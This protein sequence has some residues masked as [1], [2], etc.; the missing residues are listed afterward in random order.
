MRNLHEAFEQAKA[1]IELEG[2]KLTGEDERIIKDVASGKMTRQ[3]LLD[4]YKKSGSQ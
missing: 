1:T 4:Q 2:F 3:Q